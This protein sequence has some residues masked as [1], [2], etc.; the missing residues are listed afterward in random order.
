MLKTQLEWMPKAN[1]QTWEGGAVT[2]LHS[3]IVRTTVRCMQKSYLSNNS[4][5]CVQV[6]HGEPG[7][8]FLLW[9][10][11]S[12]HWPIWDSRVS[13][14]SGRFNTV[15]QLFI[16]FLCEG[17]W[18][19]SPS[20]FS[21]LRIEIKRV[22]QIMA[23]SYSNGTAFNVLVIWTYFQFNYRDIFLLECP[24]YLYLRITL[25]GTTLVWVIS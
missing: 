18:I 3:V 5:S 8:T 7:T 4:V 1:W 22:S 2:R 10:S 6:G 20:S 19:N 11:F 12:Y 13:I 16:R 23:L 21:N 9:S 25:T 15:E 14:L 17:L 24:L